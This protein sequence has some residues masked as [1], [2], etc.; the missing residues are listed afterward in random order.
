MFS[1]DEDVKTVLRASGWTDDRS[2]SVDAWVD[3][4]IDEGYTPFPLAIEVLRNL[5]GLEIRPFVDRSA[6]FRPYPFHFNP[7]SAGIGELD[8]YKEWQDAFGLTLFPLGEVGWY[9]LAIAEDGRVFAG[10]DGNFDL[11][12]DTVESA[13]SVLTLGRTRPVTWR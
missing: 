12:G 8:R 10:A 6:A 13:L 2:V 4:L 11:I 3:R 9:F 7:L 5:G 1:F